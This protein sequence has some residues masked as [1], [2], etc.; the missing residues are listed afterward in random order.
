MQTTQDSTM[1]RP[2]TVGSSAQKV[3]TELLVSSQCRFDF[4]LRQVRARG[5]VLG[6]RI[7]GFQG[8]GGVGH[9]GGGGG[10]LEVRVCELREVEGR[11][12]VGPHDAAELAL[13]EVLQG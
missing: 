13:R 6:F 5:G 3:I 1:K 4:G 8:F 7:S 11:L 9:V 2:A 10:L 12:E